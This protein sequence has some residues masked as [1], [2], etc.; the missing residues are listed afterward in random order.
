MVYAVNAVRLGPR[1]P[2][3]FPTQVRDV[4]DNS[5]FGAVSTWRGGRHEGCGKAPALDYGV[6]VDC[7]ECGCR[8]VG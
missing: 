6:V 3:L 5:G 7:D 1:G 4:A 8:E 2:A